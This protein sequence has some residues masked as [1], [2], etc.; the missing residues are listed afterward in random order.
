MSMQSVVTLADASMAAAARALR[1]NA[2]TRWRTPSM[3]ACHGW[4]G[5]GSSACNPVLVTRGRATS[6]LALWW[7]RVHG[8]LMEGSWTV[9]GRL[10]EGS[11]KVHGSRAR[12]LVV[13]GGDAQLG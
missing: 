1:S 13:E 11:W 3:I 8:R 12:L 10:M 6:R 5:R 2:S 7:S 4:D 9:H